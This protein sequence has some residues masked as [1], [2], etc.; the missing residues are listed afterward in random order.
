MLLH[1]RQHGQRQVSWLLS[2]LVTLGSSVSASGQ[3]CFPVVLVMIHDKLLT[4]GKRLVFICRDLLWGC[5][6]D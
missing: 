5:K 4:F 3:Y 2:W 1:Q 6:G